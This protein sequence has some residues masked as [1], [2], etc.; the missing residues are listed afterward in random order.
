MV[1]TEHH[2]HDYYPCRLAIRVISNAVP[3]NVA[4][5]GVTDPEFNQGPSFW[6]RLDII[7]LREMATKASS[8]KGGNLPLVY[9]EILFGMAM[10]LSSQPGS[11]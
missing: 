10:G 2:K 4:I 11:E 3:S 1:C 6:A 7:L 9:T 8:P 5:P